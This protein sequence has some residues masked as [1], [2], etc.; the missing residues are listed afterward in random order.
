MRKINHQVVCVLIE[1]FAIGILR[2]CRILRQCSCGFF[3]DQYSFSNFIFLI[4]FIFLRYSNIFNK[5]FKIFPVSPIY[6]F[7]DIFEFFNIF[8]CL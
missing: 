8:A 1:R 5:F 6:E 4:I 7:F 2:M 3:S